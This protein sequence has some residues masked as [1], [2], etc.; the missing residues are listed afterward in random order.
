MELLFQGEVLFYPNIVPGISRNVDG[1]IVTLICLGSTSA[2]YR[3]Q[4]LS[5][6]IVSIP[7]VVVYN[8]IPPAY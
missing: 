1:Q 7:G 4:I 2:Y 6:D 5:Q 8:G 3:L